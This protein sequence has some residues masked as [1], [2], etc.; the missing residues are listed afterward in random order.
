MK[1]DKRFENKIIMFQD[2][3][4]KLEELYKKSMG[5]CAPD[6]YQKRIN[7]LS[8]YVARILLQSFNEIELDKVIKLT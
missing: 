2:D 6:E 4:E 1:E 8:R 3:Y 5:V 7:D